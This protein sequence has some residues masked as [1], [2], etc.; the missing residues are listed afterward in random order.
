MCNSKHISICFPLTTALCN[1]AVEHCDSS[2]S[3]TNQYD[4]WCCGPDCYFCFSPLSLAADMV[5]FPCNICNSLI[6]YFKHSKEEGK[7]SVSV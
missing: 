5:C 6:K 3:Y 2:P 1:N 4:C 7:I